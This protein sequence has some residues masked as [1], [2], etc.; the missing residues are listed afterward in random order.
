MNYLLMV[1]SDGVPTDE[2][3]AAMEREI[4]AWLESLSRR[5][6]D[7]YG[8][9]LKP[10]SAARTVRVRDGE[11]LVSDGPFAETKEFIGGF[12]IIDCADLDEA[13]AIAAE[14]PVARF[15]AVEVRPF[16]R[17]GDD[18]GPTV[19]DPGPADAAVATMLRAPIADG[20]RRFLL[21][22]CLDGIPES[23]AEEAAIERDIGSWAQE[24]ERQGA[25]RYGHALA[26][27]A[28][29]TTVRVR[30]GETLLT[31]GPFAET[32]EYVGGFD[33][34]DCADVD[35]AIAVAARHP[36]ARYHCVEVREFADED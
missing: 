6:A 15:H 26:G 16:L 12:D 3:A 1:C 31:D 5:G 4:P 9:V 18:Q 17:R 10:A 23:D 36:L 11:T 29:A 32:K 25:A 27:A 2:K 30:D 34:I 8:H 13:I 20:A 28:T 33:I 24:T 22:M 35:E 21:L 7:V 19:C 14:H